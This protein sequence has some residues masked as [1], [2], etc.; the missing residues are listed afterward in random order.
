[1]GGKKTI[2]PASLRGASRVL[3][4]A[5]GVLAMTWVAVAAPAHAAELAKVRMANF[6]NTIV[7]GMFQG[8]EKGYFK[9]VA[10]G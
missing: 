8:L 5:A 4:L 10:Q 6:T 9:D 2:E 3:E 7:L 1:M